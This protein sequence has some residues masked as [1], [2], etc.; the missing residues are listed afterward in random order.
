MTDPNDPKAT[1][2]QAQG[3]GSSAA[4][5]EPAAPTMALRRLFDDFIEADPQ[6]GPQEI[7][8]TW[9]EAFCIKRVGCKNHGW[10]PG[11]HPSPFDNDDDFAVSF[12]KEINTLIY[13][14][15]Y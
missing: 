15:K 11:C 4:P 5:H 2:A 6:D 14:F 8:R 1:Q 7:N 12:P 3:S 9:P 13:Y 10:T